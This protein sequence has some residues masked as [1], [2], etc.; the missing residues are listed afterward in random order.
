[1]LFTLLFGTQR[2]TLGVLTLDV[3]V[4]EELELPGTV[5][6][7]PVEDGTEISDHIARGAPRL[8]IGGS[9]SHSEMLELGL[10]SKSRLIDAVEALEFMH[11]QRQPITVVTGLRVYEDMGIAHLRMVRSSGEKGGNWIDI[12]AELI[13]IQRVA[14]KQAEVPRTAADARG[15]AGPTA[16]RAGQSAASNPATPAQDA[17]SGSILRGILR[18]IRN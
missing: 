6:L 5:T 4:T 13:R 16:Q 17:Q 7:Y 11:E 8:H 2:S 3:L 18:G 9:V 10:L 15:K 12:D 14:L 1:M